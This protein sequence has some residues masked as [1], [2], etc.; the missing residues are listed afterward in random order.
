M[1]YG[2]HEDADLTNHTQSPVEFELKLELDGDFADQEE[3]VTK[4]QQ[5]GELTRKWHQ[6]EDGVWT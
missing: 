2:V 5:F 1:G 3:S 6:L 4:R